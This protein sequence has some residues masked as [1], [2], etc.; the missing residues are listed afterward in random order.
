MARLWLKRGTTRQPRA[1]CH[2]N[3]LV[4]RRHRPVRTHPDRPRSRDLTIF[5]CA[6]SESPARLELGP[7]MGH[8]NPP[9]FRVHRAVQSPSARPTARRRHVEIARSRSIP[10][11][12]RHQFSRF[13]FH[14]KTKD[15][16]FRRCLFRHRR[17]PTCSPAPRCHVDFSGGS[18]APQPKR[19]V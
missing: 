18:T 19:G 3:F 16:C 4:D 15:P 1:T 11:S 8:T 6:L 13:V 14:I 5:A 2:I 7:L 10:C 12:R 17:P 9:H